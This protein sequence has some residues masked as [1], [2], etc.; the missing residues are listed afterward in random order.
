M[1]DSASSAFMQTMNSASS[2]SFF[3]CDE[4]PFTPSVSL[5][6]SYFKN[7]LL[8]S[9]N[10]CAILSLFCFFL[11]VCLGGVVE[12]GCLLWKALPLKEEDACG[13]GSNWGTPKETCLC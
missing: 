3:C 8:P 1:G 12:G 2:P 13:L 5:Y 9:I 6:F 10:N 7:I 11:F 4:I